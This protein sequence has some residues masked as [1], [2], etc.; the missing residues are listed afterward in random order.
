MSSTRTVLENNKSI[1]F[2]PHDDVESWC[3]WPW[4]NGKES[5]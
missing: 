1:R 4:F 3:H 5:C 2:I